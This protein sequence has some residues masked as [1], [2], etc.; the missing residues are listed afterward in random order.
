MSLVILAIDDKM[1]QWIIDGPINSSAA[2]VILGLVDYA[3]SLCDLLSSNEKEEEERYVK[4]ELFWCLRAIIGDKEGGFED[5][6]NFS[7]RIV[8]ALNHVNLKGWKIHTP[9]SIVN[10]VNK[11]V[12][13]IVTLAA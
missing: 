8:A 4:Q 13:K 6:S 12:C 1:Q 10:F 9:K 11:D 2:A 5:H 7:K 3:K